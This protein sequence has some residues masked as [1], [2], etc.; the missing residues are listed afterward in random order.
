M[1]HGL[2]IKNGKATYVSRYVKTSKLKQEEFFGGAKFAKV[3]DQKKNRPIIDEF[4]PSART[5]SS[6]ELS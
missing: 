1:I 4:V 2:R 3:Y 6:P 5:L